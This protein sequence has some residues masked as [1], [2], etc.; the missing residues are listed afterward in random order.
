MGDENSALCVGD[1]MVIDR[2]DDALSIKPCKSIKALVS[3]SSSQ[4]MFAGKFEG[5][6]CIRSYSM[7]CELTKIYWKT[8]GKEKKI[9]NAE[10]L[11]DKEQAQIELVLKEPF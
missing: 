8:G 1:V 3:V 10:F 6:I 4:H 7:E 9:E 2:D 11:K 5:T